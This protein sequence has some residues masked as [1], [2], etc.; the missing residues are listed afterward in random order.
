MT[1]LTRSFS[2]RMVTRSRTN[3]PV[4]T[5]K[6]IGIKN[7]IKKFQNIQNK[8]QRVS[9]NTDDEISVDS[10]LPELEEQFVDC[11]SLQIDFD[12]A[13]VEWHMNKK[14]LPSGMYVYICG[15]VKKGGKVCKRCCHDKIGL[16]SGCDEHFMW[17]EIENK[18]G[19]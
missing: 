16:Y 8:K 1:I 11:V 17:E 6:R 13:S 2:K 12:E 14:V 10:I 18:Q 7:G 15:K 5:S 4:Q 9:D 19:V 3:I